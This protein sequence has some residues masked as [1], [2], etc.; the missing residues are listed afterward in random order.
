MYDDGHMH[1]SL[2]LG[3]VWKIRDQC[4]MPLNHE[5]SDTH[6]LRPY[7]LDLVRLEASVL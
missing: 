4:S 5:P 6:I 1:T 2:L 7:L 3:N